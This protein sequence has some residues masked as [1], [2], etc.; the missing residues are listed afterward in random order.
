VLEAGGQIAAPDGLD[1]VFR[2][3]RRESVH[4]Y[5]LLHGVESPRYQLIRFFRGWGS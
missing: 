3:V 2:K 4:V 1:R 5:Q